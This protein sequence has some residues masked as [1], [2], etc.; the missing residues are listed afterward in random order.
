MHPA[1]R[2]SC[3]G[4]F[5]L[6]RYRLVA[7]INKIDYLRESEF[8]DAVF[9]SSGDV[10]SHRWAKRQVVAGL[11]GSPFCSANTV[12]HHDNHRLRLSL[13]DKIVDGAS[14]A[15]QLRPGILIAT[16]TMKQVKHRITPGILLVAGRSIDGEASVG[17]GGVAV[18]PR[19]GD[20]AMRHFMHLIVVACAPI[21]I[22][23]AEHATHIAAGER[24]GRVG[25]HHAVDVHAIG[26]HFAWQGWGGVLP[27]TVNLAAFAYATVG[28]P[29]A[30]HRHLLSFGCG[31]KECHCMVVVDH[32][33]GDVGGTK[34]NVLLSVGN[35]CGCRSK[36]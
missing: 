11:T 26:V 31:D 24:V 28:F 33:R 36:E 29:V 22:K 16:A 3:D 23:Q 25:H 32:R 14:Y 30:S 35:H 18:I 8:E 13:S 34:T 9:I 6:L 19:C 4:T 12:G 7:S 27:H 21:D 2:Q 1:H 20:S 10:I 15:S 17:I 5:L